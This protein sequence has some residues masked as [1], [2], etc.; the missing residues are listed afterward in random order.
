[1]IKFF[2]IGITMLGVSNTSLVS[3][4]PTT[5]PLHTITV[6]E[7]L[8]LSSDYQSLYVAGAIDGM[9][10]VTYGYEI[11]HH[12]KFV[13]CSLRGTLGELTTRVV[14]NANKRPDFEE[15]VATLVGMTVGENCK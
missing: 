12:D 1:M 3:A 11:S 14:Q 15:S 9:T 8:K 7:F 5:G 2:L 4:S 10:F 6:A 13:G